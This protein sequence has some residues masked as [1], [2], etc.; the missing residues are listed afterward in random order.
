MSCGGGRGGGESQAV[1]F[2]KTYLLLFYFGSV[3]GESPHAEICAA[4]V[5]TVGKQDCERGRRTR[6]IEDSTSVL[7]SIPLTKNLCQPAS[8]IQKLDFMNTS[9]SDGS[10]CCLRLLTTAFLVPVS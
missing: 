2:G 1:N 5:Q 6:R 3:C 8:A 7:Q 4:L 9:H 10:S